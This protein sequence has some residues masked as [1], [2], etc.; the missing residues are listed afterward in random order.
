MMYKLNVLETLDKDEHFAFAVK[1]DVGKT[2]VKDQGDPGEGTLPQVP[3]F[4]QVFKFW[5]YL[6]GN[7]AGDRGCALWI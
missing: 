6:K 2:A 5:L 1:L 3:C 7:Q 4:T